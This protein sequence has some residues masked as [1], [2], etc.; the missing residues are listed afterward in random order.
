M[1]EIWKPQQRGSFFCATIKHNCENKDF[2]PVCQSHAIGDWRFILKQLSICIKFPLVSLECTTWTKSIFRVSYTL[3]TSLF[4]SCVAGHWYGSALFRKPM[5]CDST[6]ALWSDILVCLSASFLL[7]SLWN[8]LNDHFRPE[9]CATF[10]RPRIKSGWRNNRRSRVWKFLNS[11]ACDYWT[12]NHEICAEI[13][14]GKLTF[15]AYLWGLE[16]SV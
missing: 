9:G 2:F 13:W 6:N 16:D 12:F 4:T 8:E 7:D 15:E 10:A 5:L 1:N 11:D 3:F 14:G